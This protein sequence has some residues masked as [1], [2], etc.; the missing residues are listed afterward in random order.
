MISSFF[1]QCAPRINRAVAAC[2]FGLAA[3]AA[4]VTPEPDDDR[5]A[6]FSLQRARRVQE[7]QA[8]RAAPYRAEVA[9]MR[10]DAKAAQLHADEALETARA[11]G[12]TYTQV[13]AHRMLGAAHLL[14]QSF[15]KA[16]SVLEEGLVLARE[17]RAGLRW[18]PYLLTHLADAHLAIGHPDPRASAE[19]A[20]DLARRRKLKLAEG[21]ANV[22]RARI[23][24]RT[25]VLPASAE[26]ERSLARATEL[27]DETGAE[28]QRPRIHEERAEL[29]QRIGDEPSR[30]RHLREA[31]R[32]YVGMGATGHVDR[33]ARDL[34]ELEG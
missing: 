16:V 32:L 7:R 33:L 6:L 15:Q 17:E 4:A 19:A 8:T 2:L 29:A 3:P 12:S 30:S 11:M 27:V 5:A 23:L 26:I 18:E 14:A 10:G 22:T 1:S 25:Q 20:L 21:L 34:A 9:C 13:L 24:I 28:C 31:H